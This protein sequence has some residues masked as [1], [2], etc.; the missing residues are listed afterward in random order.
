MTIPS[1]AIWEIDSNGDNANNGGGFDS[2]SGGTDYSQ[3]PSAQLTLTDGSNL[4]TS[5]TT[6]TSTTGGFTSA[7]VGNALYVSSG[8]NANTGYYFITAFTDTNTVTID[9]AIHDGT[10]A[11]GINLKVGGAIPV[12]TDELFNS[13]VGGNKC[14]I[15]GAVSYSLPAISASSAGT[16]TS[17]IKIEGYGTTRGDFPKGADRPTLA[18]GANAFNVGEYWHLRHFKHTSTHAFGTQATGGG[19]VLHNVS[20]NN[21]SGASNRRALYCRDSTVLLCEAQSTNG[22]GIDMGPSVQESNVISCFVH[23]CAIMG[24]RGDGSD[25]NSII[26][27][28]I[29]NCGT[30]ID[31]IGGGAI[32]GNDIDSCTLGI[33][34]SAVAGGVGVVNNKITNNTTGISQSSAL[35]STIMDYNLFF[36]NVTDVSNIS[37]GDNDIT[38]NPNYTDTA[39]SDF[40]CS[41]GGAGIGAGPDMTVAGLVGDYKINIGVDQD[42]NSAGSGGG[43]HSYTWIG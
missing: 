7:M 41:S 39:G 30:G 20:S 15:K 32:V 23:D 22:Y 28:V 37:K 16:S 12:P 35:E 6:L 25:Q 33:D 8:T 40:T 17:M 11:S 38:G 4:T 10:D 42:D 13:F 31:V 29:Y 18:S 19:D 27:S 36:N 1:T 26:G 3:Q 9:R 14:Y 21:S 34:V 5:G 24:V 2:A 43:E